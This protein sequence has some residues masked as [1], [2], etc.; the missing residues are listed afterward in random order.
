MKENREGDVDLPKIEEIINLKLKDLQVLF[1]EHGFEYK[2]VKIG[3][4]EK[5]EVIIL[6]EVLRDDNERFH[7]PIPTHIFDEEDF[8][9]GESLLADAETLQTKTFL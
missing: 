6:I 9:T 1:W 3:K 5:N 8:S 4:D 2:W 7:I